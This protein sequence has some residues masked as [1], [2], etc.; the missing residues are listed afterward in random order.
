MPAPTNNTSIHA[1][2]ASKESQTE[3]VSPPS[4]TKELVEA[5]GLCMQA[6]S[7][8]LDVQTTVLADNGWGYTKPRQSLRGALPYEA[9]NYYKGNLTI[10]L[11]DFG[12]FIDC[13][14]VARIRGAE[15]V[16]EV[17]NELNKEFGVSQI[18]TLP[19]MEAYVD[20]TAKMAP[21]TNFENLQVVGDYLI[22]LTMQTLETKNLNIEAPPTLY[23][24]LISTAPLPPKFQKHNRTTEHK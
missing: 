2:T 11:Q 16:K 6:V 5:V 12:R 13:R 18:N 9:V 17:R 7:P 1:D 19:D 14:T 24:L 23:L 8:K 22:E 4:D 10:S 21:D 3:K 20:Q 15:Q